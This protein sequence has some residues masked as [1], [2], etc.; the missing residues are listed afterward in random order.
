MI[1]NVTRDQGRGRFTAAAGH[2]AAR[3]L[4]ATAETLRG[5]VTVY[6][7]HLPSVRVPGIPGAAPRHGRVTR[8]W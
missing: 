2:A 8:T 3:A 5:P 6:V 4:R 7:A 1:R